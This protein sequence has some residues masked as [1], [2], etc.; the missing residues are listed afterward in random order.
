[1]LIRK[2]SN[3]WRKEQVNIQTIQFLTWLSDIFKNTESTRTIEAEL[4]IPKSTVHILFRKR[5]QYIDR[6][7]YD[8]VSAKM[9]RQGKQR[10]R[11]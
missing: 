11:I 7:L 1:M 8:R 2:E 6:P 4:G 9:E 10:K 5:L 3:V